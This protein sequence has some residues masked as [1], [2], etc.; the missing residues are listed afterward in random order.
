MGSKFDAK[1]AGDRI[2]TFGQLLD[3]VAGRTKVIV[4]IK[5][6]GIKD[7]GTEAIAV[8]EIRQHDA[9]SYVILSSFNPFVLRRIKKL[10]AQ[11]RTMFIFRDIEPFDPT[12]YRKIPF[13]LKSEPCRR[14]IRKFIQPDF[15]SIETTVDST[16]ID[17]LQARGYPVFLWAPNDRPQL[18]VSLSRRSHGIITD[19]PLL[20]M[21]VAERMPAAPDRPT[22]NQH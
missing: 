17:R 1:F 8:N 7:E 16:T 9:Y 12:Q 20:A 13:F 15:L 21:E 14:A 6:G 19:E 10:D 11:V 3:E 5:A 22:D 4:E 2:V 18:Q